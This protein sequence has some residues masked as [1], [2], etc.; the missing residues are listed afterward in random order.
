[1]PWG[2][3]EH[4]ERL[5]GHQS[6]TH[7]T[8]GACRGEQREAEEWVLTSVRGPEVGSGALPRRAGIEESEGAPSQA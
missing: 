6:I 2:G 3:S 1:M 4:A 5:K 7:S 8:A